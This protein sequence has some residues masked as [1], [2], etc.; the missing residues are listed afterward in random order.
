MYRFRQLATNCLVWLAA[1]C[2]PFGSSWASSCGCQTTCPDSNGSP[3]R[4]TTCCSVSGGCYSSRGADLAS[5]C[6]ESPDGQCQS[7]GNVASGCQCR[8]LD[9]QQTSDPIAAPNRGVETEHLTQPSDAATASFRIESDPTS[10]S[11]H[12][13]ATSHAPSGI[14][15]CILLCRFTL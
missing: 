4:V 1:I 15:R 7:E 9:D 8:D 6:H 13:T 3:D 5:C 11:R 10:G 2:V 14:E 12:W